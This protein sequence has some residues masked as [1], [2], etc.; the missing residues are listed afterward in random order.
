MGVP[1]EEFP[2]ET[3]PDIN[4]LHLNPSFDK[5]IIPTTSGSEMAAPTI[6]L[7][8]LTFPDDPVELTNITPIKIKAR[9]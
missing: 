2:F 9:Y 1:K 3:N 4:L 8:R 5:G 7:L 6:L